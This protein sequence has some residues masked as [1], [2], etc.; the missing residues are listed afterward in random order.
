LRIFVLRIGTLSL[1][2]LAVVVPVALRGVLAD[3]VLVI[4]ADIEPDGR[5]ER[6]VLVDAEPGQLLI[7]NLS[8]FLAE[9]ADGDAPIRN[10]ATDTMNKLANGGFTF[11]S[12]LFTVKLFGNDNF[13]RQD[14]P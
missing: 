8:I 11:G 13:C 14:R 1:T 2:C 9:I 12:V 4:E 5:V 6:T 7:K 10:G 3:S